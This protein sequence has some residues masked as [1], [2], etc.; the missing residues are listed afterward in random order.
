MLSQ[1]SCALHALV[2]V[3]CMHARSLGLTSGWGWRVGIKQN[4]N[5]FWPAA[6]VSNGGCGVNYRAGGIGF[7]R[8]S[9]LFSFLFSPLSSRFLLESFPVTNHAPVIYKGGMTC[10]PISIQ[11]LFAFK[12]RDFGCFKQRDFVC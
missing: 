9:L 5:W 2:V 4:S 6:P 8:S 11:S 10:V 7:D 1:H 12:Q 3:L